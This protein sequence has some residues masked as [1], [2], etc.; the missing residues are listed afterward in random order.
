MAEYDP[1]SFRDPESRVLVGEGRVCRGLS[2]AALLDWEALEATRFF[3]KAMA[4]GRIVETTRTP[5]AEIQDLIHAPAQDWAAI[6]EHRRVPFLSYPYEWSFGMLKDAA[7]LQLDLLLDALGENLILKD[8]SAFNTQWIGSRPVFIDVGSFRRFGPGEPWEGYRQFCQMFLFP[9]QL[10]AY[11]GVAFQPWLRGSIDGISP[12]EMSRLLSKR[13]LLRAGVLLHVVM[14]ARLQKRYGG[15]DRSIRDDLRKGGFNTEMVRATVVRMR[16]LVAGLDWK[17]GRSEWSE[18]S[19]EHSY[20]NEDFSLKEDFVA[21]VASQQR[22]RQVWDLGCNTGHFSRLAA[23][24]SDCVIAMDIDHLAVDRLYRQL[25][26]ENE[27]KILPLVMN[28]AQPSPGLGWRGEERRSLLTRG[29]P[30][31]TL[32]LA[33]I[34]HLVLTATIPIPEVLRFLASLGGDFVIEFPTR[35]DPMVEKLLLHKSQKHEDYNRQEFERHLSTVFSVNKSIKIGS[36]TRY[37]YH[38]TADS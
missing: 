5:P 20:D 10:Q 31:L 1:G 30:D 27:E 18:Y 19:E 25:R 35:D 37:L 13:D 12:E 22:W 14:Q 34:H 9:L 11:K 21:K 28:L 4:E 32:C 33:L 26:A 15:T 24:H 38:A 16:K 17:V 36:G 8:A 6:L 23:R 2:E 29:K 3:P 7:L